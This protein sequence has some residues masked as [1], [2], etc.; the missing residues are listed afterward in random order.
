[1][2]FLTKLNSSKKHRAPAYPTKQDS[3]FPF[4]YAGHIGSASNNAERCLQVFPVCSA[5]TEELLQIV[6]NANKFSKLNPAKLNLK[7][8]KMIANSKLERELN[9]TSESREFSEKMRNKM[10]K[11]HKQYIKRLN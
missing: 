7:N 3:S 8:D 2:L 5:S 9:P 11:I 1:M 4:F 6:S 10:K